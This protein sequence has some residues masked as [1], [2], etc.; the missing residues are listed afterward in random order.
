MNSVNRFSSRVENYAKFR[1]GYPPGVLEILNSECRLTRHSVIADVG[2]GT[3][4]LSEVFLK[5][6]NAVFGIEPN[7]LMRTTAE[8]LLKGFAHFNSV[9]A[10]AEK[11]T[12]PDSSIDFVTAGQ[13][14]HWFDRE[15]AK[16]EFVRILKPDGW[17]VLI[18]NARRVGSTAFLREYEALL[19]RYSADYAQVRHEHAEE[20]IGH[21]FAPHAMKSAH[22][23][24][25]QRFDF[26]SL[27]GRL[28]SS[29]YAPEAGDPNF[30]RMMTELQKIFDAHNENG[31]VNFE[32]DTR[33]YYGHLGG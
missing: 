17:V 10:T 25:V 22:L 9:A 28:C 16:Q 5:N 11:T 3:G 19:L 13:A 12:L 21:F 33:V 1:P 8:S 23:D 27:K 14:F 18:W 26:Q 15:A 32:Y 7:E 2:S 30:D 20:G 24:N 31:V 6:C 29:S 4:L